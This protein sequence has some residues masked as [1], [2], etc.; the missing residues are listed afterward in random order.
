V[1]HRALRRR[2]QLVQPNLLARRAGQPAPP[3]VGDWPAGVGVAGETTLVSRLGR[4]ITRGNEMVAS[5][6]IVRGD[7]DPTPGDAA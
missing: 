3:A 6:Q 7:T 2:L 5:R 1:N 4:G